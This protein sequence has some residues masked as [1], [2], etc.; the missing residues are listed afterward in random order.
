MPPGSVAPGCS[1]RRDGRGKDLQQLGTE[2]KTQ[3]TIYNV[4]A[5]KFFDLNV[6]GTGTLHR[7]KRQPSDESD[8]P[9]VTEGQPQ[10]YAHLSWLVALGARHSGCRALLALF[11][12]LRSVLR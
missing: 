8:S 3:A 10:I 5:K 6:T 4:T 11:R 12:A 9:K 2:P 1:L 7:P